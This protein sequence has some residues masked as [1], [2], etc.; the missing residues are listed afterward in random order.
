MTAAGY[1]S[2][3]AKFGRPSTTTLRLFKI[4]VRHTDRKANAV[5]TLYPQQ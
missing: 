3:L 5:L 1:D 2:E 4:H